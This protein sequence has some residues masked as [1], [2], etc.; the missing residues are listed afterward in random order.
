M[1]FAL[2]LASSLCSPSFF[3]SINLDCSLFSWT[4][5]A[6]GNDLQSCL[7]ISLWKNTTTHKT[8]LS[9]F[10][11]SFTKSQGWNLNALTHS[12]ILPDTHCSTIPKASR[13][14]PAS[15]L[16]PVQLIL[17]YS[18]LHHYSGDNHFPCCNVACI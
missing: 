4:L 2:Y 13:L 6:L 12:S 5:A 3:A 9:A 14:P 16:K 7:Q 18:H 15:K 10:T 17:A 11:P 8:H 1:Y